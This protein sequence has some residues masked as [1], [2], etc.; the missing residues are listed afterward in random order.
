MNEQMRAILYAEDD[1]SLREELMEAMVAAGYNVLPAESGT[2][3]ITTLRSEG[4]RIVGLVTDINIGSGPDGW[5]VARTARELN[6]DIPVVYVSAHS[7]EVWAA[8]GV[9]NSV[10]IA[11][12]FVATQVVVALSM[13]L[14]AVPHVPQSSSEAN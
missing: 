8:N 9:P 14:N 13:A 6:P 1:E 4:A 2:T 10:M 7:D 12:P 3:A 5:E 11:K